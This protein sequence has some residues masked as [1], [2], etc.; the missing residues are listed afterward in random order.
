MTT[1]APKDWIS[2]VFL[3]AGL[4]NIGGILVFSLGFTN[5][6]LTTLYPEVF[7]WLG[8]VAIILWGLAYASVANSYAAVPWLVAVFALEKMV[9]VGTWVY[10]HARH[11][12]QFGDIVS[13]SPLTAMFYAVYGA[14]D[15]GFGLFFLWVLKRC[16]AT[17]RQAI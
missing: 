13:Q 6:L 3:L 8:L 9:Y 2:Q 15:L 17:T 16:L 11:W 10:W 14:G 1:P 4:Y 12:G 5:T 7:S